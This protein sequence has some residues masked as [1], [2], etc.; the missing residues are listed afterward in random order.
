[1]RSK[2]KSRFGL[3]DALIWVKRAIGIVAVIG[4]FYL[5]LPLEMIIVAN[6]EGSV[7]TAEFMRVITAWAT[8]LV[9]DILLIVLLLFIA[10]LTYGPE[11]LDLVGGS[12]GRNSPPR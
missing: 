1:M 11:A 2:Q 8:G 5:T 7:T 10:V 6:Q 12:E 4:V 3:V 9:E